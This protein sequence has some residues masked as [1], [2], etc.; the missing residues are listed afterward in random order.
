MI[1]RI[2][3]LLAIF[4]AIST[5]VG[6]DSSAPTPQPS[7]NNSTGFTPKAITLR[8]VP[9]AD[10]KELVDENLVFVDKT[11]TEWVAPKGTVTDGASVPRLALWMTD[12]RFAKGFLKAAVVHD[13]YCQSDNETRSPNQYRAMPW[14][15]VHR[16][17]Y[18]A[19]IAAGTTPTE[20]R[21]MFAAVWLG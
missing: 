11:G 15:S 7:T 4:T 6:C 17:F 5:L 16:M 8:E 19:M 3:S 2:L 1:Y 20:A 10:L 21:L 13:A 18:E 14:K 12:G 9:G